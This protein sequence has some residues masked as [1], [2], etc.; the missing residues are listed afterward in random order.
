LTREAQRGGGASRYYLAKQKT[1]A[2]IEW[3]DIDNVP[4]SFL[5]GIFSKIYSDNNVSSR[6][7]ERIKNV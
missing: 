3:T 7:A 6:A 2:S 5:D 4:G 1:V